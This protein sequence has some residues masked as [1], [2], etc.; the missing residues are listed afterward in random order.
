MTIIEW[1]IIV[2]PIAIKTVVCEDPLDFEN[3]MISKSHI[4]ACIP[5][6]FPWNIHYNGD[7][8]SAFLEPSN[9]SETL[10]KCSISLTWILR[11]SKGMMSLFH[12][13]SRA[14]ENSEV[15]TIHP[16]TMYLSHYPFLHHSS[17]LLIIPNISRNPPHF[18]A[19]ISES[20]PN[21]I[22]K[23]YH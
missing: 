23:T 16:V 5:G 13:N 19:L 10:V 2:D 17:C 14:R 11:P 7:S 1:I 22:P 4:V 21:K 12:Q 20:Y 15:V 8:E 3:T 9:K 18:I 6:I